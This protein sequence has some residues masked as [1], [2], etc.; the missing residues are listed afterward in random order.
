LFGLHT[1]QSSGAGRTSYAYSRTIQSDSCH[2]RQN[3]VD[4]SPHSGSSMLP[5]IAACMIPGQVKNPAP[6]AVE[7]REERMAA[8]SGLHS[9]FALLKTPR[10]LPF[11]I[12][13][14]LGAFN[15]NVFKNALVIFVTFQAAGLTDAGVN[16]LINTAA[17]LFILPF[18]LFSAFA[19][20]LADKFEKSQIIRRIKLAEIGIMLLAGLGFFV[21][22][23][24]FLIAVL[25]IMGTQSAFFGPVKYSILPQH[26][27]ESELVGGNALVEMGTFLAILVGTIVGGILA[28]LGEPGRGWVSAVVLL[29]AVFGW[30]SS[31][32]IPKARAPAPDLELSL[33]P[34]SLTVRVLRYTCENRVVF[35]SVLGIS[36]FWFYGAL[37]LAQLPN[38]TKTVLGGDAQVVT[39]LLA[40]F[41]IGIGL[42]SLLCERMSGRKVEIGLVPFGAVGLTV[43][44]FDLA[45]ASPERPAETAAGIGAFLDQPG[46]ARILLDLTLMAIFGGFYSV[47]LYALVQQRTR[48]ENRA[49]VIAGNNILNALFMVVSALFAIGMLNAGV[50]IPN[51]FLAVGLMN[52]AVAVYIFKLVP[53]F[54][55]RFIVWMLVHSVY[56]L[57]VKNILVIP[58][59]GPAVLACNHVSFVD[60]LIIMAACPRP[61]RFIMHHAI[62]GMPIMSFVFRTAGAIPVASKREDPALREAAFEE[63]ATALEQGDLIGIFPEGQITYDGEVGEFRPGIERIVARNPVPVVPMAL[64]GLYGSFFSRVGGAAMSKPL[65]LLT[66]FWSEIEL[67]AAEPVPAE[68]VSAVNLRDTVIRLRAER[69]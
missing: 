11:F 29:V 18:F 22:H 44:A 34:V 49:R 47:P 7:Q 53:E 35:R 6:A 65:L 48:A 5:F 59:T 60:A 8:R 10:F 25:F 62:F 39:L 15:D 14:F 4:P 37:F 46:S 30:V 45:F 23:T 54:L 36:W 51:L 55:M 32:R 42:G 67:I 33:N 57:R 3:C 40:T 56:R 21:Q 2:G 27:K 68:V 16:T 52:V 50:T 24:G 13:Q 61:I 19:G 38:Y 66:R 26:L 17:G 43:F 69:K 20:Q 1:L 41:S 58:E 28:G 31:R 12:T 9:Q 64:R 63:V